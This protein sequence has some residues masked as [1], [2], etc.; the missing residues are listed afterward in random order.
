MSAVA[1]LEP[2]VSRPPSDTD[3]IVDENANSIHESARSE[4]S[5]PLKNAVDPYEVGF[6]ENDPENPK[7]RGSAFLSLRS[8]LNVK[9]LY[10]PGRER[11][12]GISLVL[13]LCLFSMRESH[14]LRHSISPLTLQ[15]VF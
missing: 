4:R 12:D 13:Q 15:T 9:H 1:G 2:K 11:S 10:R 3:T 5:N 8:T 14:L 6:A 7:V